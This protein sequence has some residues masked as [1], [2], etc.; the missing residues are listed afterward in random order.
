VRFEV[1]VKQDPSVKAGDDLAIRAANLLEGS[2]VVVEGVERHR[3]HPGGGV[4][5]MILASEI[6]L[7]GLPQDGRVAS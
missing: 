1:W 3:P 4:I 6:R 7:K 2:L 5:P